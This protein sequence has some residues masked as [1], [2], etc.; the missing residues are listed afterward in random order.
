MSTDISR[1]CGIYN[2]TYTEELIIVR[3]KTQW[4]F[5]LLGILFIFTLPFYASG[6]ILNVMNYIGIL[7]VAALGLH[8]L[9]GCAGQISMGQSAFM[10]VGA[11]VTAILIREAHWSFFMAVPAAALVCGL[12]GI[13]VGL[14]SLRVRG[15]YLVM[16]S[17]AAQVIIPWLLSHAWPEILGGALGINVPPIQIADYKFLEQGD[18]YYVIWVVVLLGTVFAINLLRTRVGRALIAIRDNDLAAEL[19]GISLLRYKLLAFFICSLYAGV[20]GGL[21]AEWMRALTADQFN[22][23]LSVL[24]LGMLIV[25]GAGSCTGVFMGVFFLIGV[26]EIAKTFAPVVGEIFGLPS[27]TLAPALA[28]IVFGLVILLFLIFEPRGLAH[29]WQLFKISYRLNPFSY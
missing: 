24:F 1:P 19:M 13:I 12:I 27:G 15:F 6:Y 8:I 28:P 2:R 9:M 17:L 5:L 10:G 11:Y 26:D 29:R 7:I 14:P 25:G 20:A 3:T 22:L 21:W 18:I 16:A 4:F 23:H